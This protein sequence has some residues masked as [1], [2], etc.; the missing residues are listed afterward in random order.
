MSSFISSFRYLDLKFC[1]LDLSN[2]TATRINTFCTLFR[3]HLPTL[4]RIMD[5]LCLPRL[6]SNQIGLKRG[7]GNEEFAFPSFTHQRR[8]LI[9]C[10]DGHLRKNSDI[11]IY[12]NIRLMYSSIELLDFQCSYLHQTHQNI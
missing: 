6:R 12:R 5:T 3:L 4:Y 10:R 1:S 7:K 8:I 11:P 9:I 2:D